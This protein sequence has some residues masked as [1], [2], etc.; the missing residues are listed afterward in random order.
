MTKAIKYF[1]TLT[2]TLTVLVLIRMLKI[3]SQV[4]LLLIINCF[5]TFLIEK[6]IFKK[7]PVTV[8][9]KIKIIKTV[10]LYYNYANLWQHCHHVCILLF[11]S[12]TVIILT[13][14]L[15]YICLKFQSLNCSFYLKNILIFWT[16]RRSKIRAG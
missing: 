13:W 6:Y 2:T 12:L 5:Q 15:T 4:Y 14:L 11:T 8:L 10:I 16:W 9:V 1:I 7:Q 3:S